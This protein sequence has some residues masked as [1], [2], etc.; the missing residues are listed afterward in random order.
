MM[1]SQTATGRSMLAREMLS[2]MVLFLSGQTERDQS[3]ETVT[4]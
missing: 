3:P 4:V 1:V 2:A